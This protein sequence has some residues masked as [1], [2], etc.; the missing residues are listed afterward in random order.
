MSAIIISII[1]QAHH[2]RFLNIKTL[3]I[4]AYFYKHERRCLEMLFLQDGVVMDPSLGALAGILAA[5]MVVFAIVGVVLWIFLSLAFMKIAKRLGQSMPG[6]A[7]IPGIGP[8]IVAYRA[9]GMHW[10]PWLLLIGYVIPLVN[11]IF[12]IAFAVFSIIWM[13]KMLE[14]LGRPGWWAILI[15]IIPVVNLI[16]IGI[17]AWGGSSNSAP[18]KGKKQK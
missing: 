15:A 3:F 14:A 18:S 4:L 1:I 8:L 11:F 12:A 5:F 17:A 16:L 9:S 7:W 2:H 13:W 10:W 6:L